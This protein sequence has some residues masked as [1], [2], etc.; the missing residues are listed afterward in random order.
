M[1]LAPLRVYIAKGHNLLMAGEKDFFGARLLALIFQLTDFV[2][3]R[4]C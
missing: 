1:I 2:Y 4:Y 3:Q